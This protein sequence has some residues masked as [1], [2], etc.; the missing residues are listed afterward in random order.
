MLR[1]LARHRWLLGLGALL[2]LA[3]AVLTLYRVTPGLPPTIAERGGRSSVATAQALLAAADGGS[4][5][6]D[7][8]IATTI[9]ARASLVADLAATDVV[10][11]RI[12]R[13]AG[14]DP[15]QLAIFGPAAGA[16]AVPVP[17]AVE[18]TDASGL[19]PEAAVVRLEAGPTQPIITIRAYAAQ[20]STA[21]GLAGATRAELENVVRARAGGAPVVQVERLG[22]V[23]Q[24]TVLSEPKKAVAFV[25]FVAVFVL[26]CSGVILVDGLGRR[27]RTS[28]S[29][30]RQTSPV[31]GH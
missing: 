2:A 1:I 19:A 6:L 12:A 5:Q 31:T 16:P 14:M 18:A 20:A 25:A 17:L 9:P 3:T 23:T 29:V 21:V 11:A 15:A 10:R 7:S 24:R 13:R 8:R 22:L 28:R 4:Y 30:R 27:A 26:W